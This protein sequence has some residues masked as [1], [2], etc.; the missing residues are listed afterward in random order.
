[1]MMNANSMDEEWIQMVGRFQNADAVTLLESI[2]K[3]PAVEEE[4][5]LLCDS[6][7]RL[8]KNVGFSDNSKLQ[9][10]LL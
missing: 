7:V 4:S 10:W 2:L 8:C 1:M 9:N 3:I 6:S 5:L